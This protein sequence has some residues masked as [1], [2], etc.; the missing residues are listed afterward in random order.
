METVQLVISNIANDTRVMPN[1]VN[2]M[3]SNSNNN[4][5]VNSTSNTWN[6]VWGGGRGGRLNIRQ[7]LMLGRLHNL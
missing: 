6:S 3:A 1:L 5:N 2:V 4:E 7:I